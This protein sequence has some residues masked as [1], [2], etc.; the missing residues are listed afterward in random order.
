VATSR[1]MSAV[2]VVGSPKLFEPECRSPRQMQLANA[3]CAYLEMAK[4]VDP[5]KIDWQ[6]AAGTAQLRLDYET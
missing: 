2:I 4:T 1:A 6:A 5:K 3:L